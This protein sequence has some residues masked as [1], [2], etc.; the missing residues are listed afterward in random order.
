MCQSDLPV[1]FDSNL[2]NPVGLTPV[3]LPPPALLCPGLAMVERK[4]C[5]DWF[6]DGEFVYTF[7]NEGFLDKYD[8]LVRNEAERLPSKSCVK[9]L[10][11]L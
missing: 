1:P 4:T 11:A 7:S 10:C 2:G 9:S 6:M 8:S 3:P 5:S